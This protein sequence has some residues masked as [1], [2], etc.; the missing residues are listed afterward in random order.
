MKPT[1]DGIK[2][3]IKGALI[4]A[5]QK[6]NRKMWNSVEDLQILRNTEIGSRTVMSQSIIEVIW[7][8][9]RQEEMRVAC[10]GAAFG[11]Q[12]KLVFVQF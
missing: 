11:N 8:P 10:N 1:L 6:V 12:D 2:K 5:A 9:P 3:R 4:V 7:K